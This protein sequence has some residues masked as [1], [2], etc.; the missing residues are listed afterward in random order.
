MSYRAGDGSGMTCDFGHWEIASGGASSGQEVE[1]VLPCRNIELSSHSSLFG[2]NTG[3]WADARFY[4]YLYLEWIPAPEETRNKPGIETHHL[5]PRLTELRPGIPIATYV[6]YESHSRPTG[7]L[8]TF[9]SKEDEFAGFAGELLTS[10]VCENLDKF[11]HIFAFVDL[12]IAL[13]K[14]AAW[15]WCKPTDTGYAYLAGN[16]PDTGLLGVLCM[17]G[18]RQTGARQAYEIDQNIVPAGSIGGYLISDERFLLDMVLPVLPKKFTN[19]KTQDW[20]VT[21]PETP[22]GRY[23]YTLTLKKPFE[24]DKVTHDGA[25]YQPVM[26]RFDVSMVGGHVQITTATR[27]PIDDYVTAYCDT[28]HKYEIGL[29]SSSQIISWAQLDEP[30]VTY[31]VEDKTPQGLKLAVEIGGGILTAVLIMSTGGAGIVIGAIVMGIATGLANID[32]AVAA[33]SENTS[34]DPCTA[35][36]SNLQGAIRWPLGNTFHLESAAINGPLQLGFDPH[37]ASDDGK[38]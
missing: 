29:D 7:T 2:E 14:Y 27:T 26:T 34:P 32:T 12:D 24:L 35:F 21:N 1:F 28:V 16:S 4:I 9:F 17:T 25:K 23:T 11:A 38:K 22:G 36:A 3:T 30:I 15:A 19:A 20:S 33:W 8:A 5:V 10:W 6:T 37:L 31:H 18:G 13:D